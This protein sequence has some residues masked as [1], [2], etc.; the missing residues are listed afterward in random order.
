MSLTGSKA[1]RI[2]FENALTSCSEAFAEFDDFSDIVQKLNQLQMNG[3]EK[4]CAAV[5]RNESSFNV[6]THGDLWSNNILFH[7]TDD[8]PEP[9]FVSDDFHYEM[10]M[11]RQRHT[12]LQW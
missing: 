4:C 12:R 11:I 10:S 6:L 1:Y 5:E 7:L 2:L 9:I 8:K 3:F